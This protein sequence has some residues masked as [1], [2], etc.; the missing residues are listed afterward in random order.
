MNDP[1]ESARREM[2]EEINAAPFS[3]EAL[4]KQYGKVYDTAQL[5]AEFRVTGFLA[6]F[7]AVERK[8]DGAEGTMMFQHSPRLYYCFQAT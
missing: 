5:Q 1:T 2:V 3:R 4:E 6:P 7:V 8:S